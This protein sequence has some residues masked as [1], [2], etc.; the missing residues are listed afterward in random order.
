MQTLSKGI[1]PGVQAPMIAVKAA[2][3]HHAG[4]TRA[5]SLIKESRAINLGNRH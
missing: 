5:D 4:K 1:E 2:V 3:H